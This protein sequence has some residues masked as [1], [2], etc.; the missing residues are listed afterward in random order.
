MPSPTI[1]NADVVWI[2]GGNASEA[3][4]RRFKWVREAK[5]SW[6]EVMV[7]DPRFT[8]SAA[9]ADHYA[10]IQAGIRSRRLESE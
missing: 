2:M 6:N 9:G 4:P 1:K 3:H 8:H 5:P 10:P 7:V